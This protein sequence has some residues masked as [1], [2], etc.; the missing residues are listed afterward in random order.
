MSTATTTAPVFDP[1]AVRVLLCD[2]DGNLF[3][4]EDLAFLA[5]ADV[6]NCCLAELGVD[7]TFDA[8]EL[9][10]AAT[11]KNFRS[12][13]AELA[14]DNGATDTL[15]PERLQWW[16][17]EEQ[18]AVA[19]YL[20][21]QLEHDPRVAEPLTRMAERFGL[22]I[23]SSSALPRLDACFR[24]TGLATLFP[25]EHRY[26]AEDSLPEPTSKPDP[27]VYL[28]AGRALGV[29]GAEGLAIEDSVP[30]ATSAVAAGFPTIGNLLFVREDERE[31]RRAQLEAVGVAAI[32]S[33]WAELE[34][35]LR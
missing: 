15:T 32:V 8:E 29:S 24:A 2:A 34:T 28:H 26:S 25:A 20:G 17:D 18:R 23:V 12:T 13:I 19:A 21:E 5:S 10:L 7:R 11:G 22:A 14:R 35:L 27:A 3:P 6:T 31:E 1:A 9:R 30:G 4:S 33:S 16:G